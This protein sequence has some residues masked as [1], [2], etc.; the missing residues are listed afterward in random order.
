M[1][2]TQKEEHPSALT[3]QGL[4]QPKVLIRGDLRLYVTES[5]VTLKPIKGSYSIEMAGMQEPLHILWHA[6]GQVFRRQARST[7]IEFD[8]RGTRAGQTRIY[9]VAVQVVE[10]GVQGRVVQSGAFVHIFVT[11]NDL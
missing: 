3:G 1:F 5:E 7:D 9:L 8:L 2:P 6:E 4:Q 10:R 11:S